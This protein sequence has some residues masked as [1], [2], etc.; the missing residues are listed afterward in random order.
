MSNN[1]ALRGWTL[2]RTTPKQ[3]CTDETIELVRRA[4]QARDP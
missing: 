4:L 2:L 1:A 3:L